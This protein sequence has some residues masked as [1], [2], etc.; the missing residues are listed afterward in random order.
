MLGHSGSRQVMIYDGMEGPKFDQIFA[1]GQPAGAIFS[2]DGIRYAYC[3]LIGNESV[4]MVDGRELLR[5]SESIG[6]TISENSCS[7]LSFTSNSKHVYF[8][9]LVGP[10]GNHAY[11]RFV[12]DGKVSPTGADGDNRGYYFSPDGNHV[13]YQWNDPSKP[14]QQPVLIVDG[15]PAGYSASNPQWSADSQHL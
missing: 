14:D 7:L 9:R 8:W 3:G 10:D 4:V 1:Q 6:G 11:S 12:F 13:A 2:P 15:K 5:S